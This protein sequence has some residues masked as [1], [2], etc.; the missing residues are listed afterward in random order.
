MFLESIDIVNFRGIRRLSLRLEQTTVLIGENNAGKSTIL[1]AVLLA[2]GSISARGRQVFVKDDH[3]MSG[4]SSQ[5]AD[6]DAIEIVLRF[7]EQNTKW[8]REI[9]QKL[10]DVIQLG[11]DGRRCVILRVR[12]TYNSA[13]NESNPE[14]EFMNLNM[15]VLST[16]GLPMSKLRSLVPI[17]PLKS[18]RDTGKEF[19]PT[20]RFWRPFVSSS[21]MEPDTRHALETELAD[22]N[23]RIVDG[24]ESFDAIK[25]QL[26]HMSKL[27]PLTD[28]S[29][30]SIEALPPNVRDILSKAKVSLASIT[31]AKIP[32]E[33]HG[34][35]TQSLAVIYLFLAYL[36]NKIS[37]QYEM[38]SP[39]LTVEEPEA[40]L[41][42]SAA[43]SAAKLLSNTQGQNIIA[44]HSGDMIA[45]FPVEFLRFLRRKGGEIA[46]FQ[47]DIDRFDNKSLRSINYHIQNTRGNILFARCW[48]LVEGRTDR[49]VFE[50]CAS[51][52]KADLT[53]NG[54]YCLEYAQLGTPRMLIEFAKQIGIRCVIVADGDKKG[55]DYIKSAKK[56]CNKDELTHIHQLEYT[57]D[58]VLCLAGYGHHYEN[59]TRAKSTDGPKDAAYWKDVV[60]NIKNGK[61]D[62]AES[63]I[64]EMRDAGDRES[65]PAIIRNI[66]DESIRLA[67][68]T[69][70]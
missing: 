24:H 44:T 19:G 11:G 51:V 61:P 57:M 26:G 60:D 47:V 58:V 28:T 32:I 54:V 8:P 40:H 56:S 46:V 70:T 3:H 50:Q 59:N 35:G 69:T 62:V 63:A 27:V 22:L 36:R 17:F 53:L 15:K 42:P 66:I 68:G 18:T 10:Q 5:A 29:P 23:R 14:W 67:G 34:E 41:H 45:G 43:Y 38:A 12:S 31:G 13:T 30:V 25:D 48:L 7:A 6:G 33:R 2:L 21:T 9:S 16:N 1:D 4:S 37:E 52:Y 65:I 55:A 20:S 39:I 49:L 64:E